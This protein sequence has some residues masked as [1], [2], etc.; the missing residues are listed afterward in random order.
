MSKET[1]G[2]TNF[3]RLHVEFDKGEVPSNSPWR[4]VADALAGRVYKGKSTAFVENMAGA[5]F[6]Q[7]RRDISD[8]WKDKE[9]G[10]SEEQIERAIAMSEDKVAQRISRFLEGNEVTA[11]NGLKNLLYSSIDVDDYDKIRDEVKSELAGEEKRMVNVKAESIK[12]P[13]RLEVWGVR[14][15]AVLGLAGSVYFGWTFL[16]SGAKEARAEDYSGYAPPTMAVPTPEAKATEL[17]AAATPFAVTSDFQVADKGVEDK[18][19]DKEPFKEG[20]IDFRKPFTVVVP[21]ETAKAGR[22]YEGFEIEV[23]PLPETKI[24]EWSH[25]DEFLSLWDVLSRRSMEVIK[26]DIGATMIVGHSFYYDT[27]GD[28]ISEPLP[29]NWVQNIGAENMLGKEMTIN[30]EESEQVYRAVAGVKVPAW[31]LSA[32]NDKLWGS[33]VGGF[34]AR[35]DEI[36]LD[37]KLRELIKEK[38]TLVMV[39]CD[40]EFSGNP[41]QHGFD[42]TLV[43][44]ERVE[45]GDEWRMP[46]PEWDDGR[47]N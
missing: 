27:N 16:K 39:V 11:K 38:N 37:D 9:K 45:P 35:T 25:L 8:S 34:Y 22:A 19:P 1:A 23:N 40:D 36:G 10:W 32:R 17:P 41:D 18:M 42:R 12:L 28:G 15:L 26:T 24:A 30:Q 21:D 2:L 3:E 20:K 7:M 46:G 47:G 29:F 33:E 44:W 6:S 43:V 5:T 13:D 31:N 14:A 4:K